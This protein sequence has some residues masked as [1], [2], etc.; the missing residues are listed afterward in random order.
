MDKDIKKLLDNI[1][2]RRAEILYALCEDYQVYI[3]QIIVGLVN[4]IRSL[5]KI[6]KIIEGKDEDRFKMEKDE[7]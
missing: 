7:E 1:R 3:P 2:K 6:I 5:T 4:E